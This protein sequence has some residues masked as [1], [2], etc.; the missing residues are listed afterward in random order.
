[1]TFLLYVFPEQLHVR[2][3]LHEERERGGVQRGP[4]Q[5]AAPRVRSARVSRYQRARLAHVRTKRTLQI[6][7]GSNW[8][9]ELTLSYVMYYGYTIGETASWVTIQCVNTQNV[10]TKCP[11]MTIEDI[12]TKC[13]EMTIE[14]TRTKCLWTTIENARTNTFEWL[15][16]TPEQSAF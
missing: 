4:G 16:K 9:T 14:D 10:R 5:H 12:R 6:L 15:S 11:Q 7:I 13:L 3:R 8:G 1:M 2:L